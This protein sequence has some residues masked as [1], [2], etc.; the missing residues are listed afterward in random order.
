MSGD[1]TNAPAVLAGARVTATVR[2]ARLSLV[3]GAVALAG[4]VLAAARPSGGSVPPPAFADLLRLAAYAGSAMFCG[5]VSFWTCVVRTPRPRHGWLLTVA[6]LGIALL[7]ASAVGGL[8]WCLMHGSYADRAA[9]SYLARLGIGL[10]TAWFLVDP[11]SRPAM[12]GLLA[13]ALAISVTVVTA[14]PEQMGPATVIFTTLHVLAASCW[15]GGLLGLA[16]GFIPRPDPRRLHDV[17]VRFPPVSIT[18]VIVLAVTGAYHGWAVAGSW[19]VLANTTYGHRL[20]DKLV[21]VGAMLL[22]GLGSHLYV[23]S[24]LGRARPV[25][26]LA[27]CVGAELALGGGALW[28]TLGLTRAAFHV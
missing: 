19:H 20:L 16:V 14:R 26:V 5:M 7:L 25:Q 4:A 21:L 10:L 2:A 17:V 28:V 11:S 8:G 23:R 24:L 27:L 22:A 1:L 18:C 15:L 9:I 6:R 12:P 3:L 13:T